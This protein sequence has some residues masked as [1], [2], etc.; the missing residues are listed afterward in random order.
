MM[1]RTSGGD[2]MAIIVNPGLISSS[3]L[4][5]STGLIHST[6]LIPFNL[7]FL[8]SAEEFDTNL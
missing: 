2:G 1:K 7:S 8:T 6:E 3:G 5:P 4:I